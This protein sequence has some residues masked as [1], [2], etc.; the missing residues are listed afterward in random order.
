MLLSD[1]IFI[2][3]IVL[4]LGWAAIAFYARCR[5]VKFDHAINHDHVFHCVGCDYIYTDDSD[6]DRSLCP[7]C[8]KMNSSVQF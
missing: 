8:G 7:E 4:L 3:L 5:D 1:I 2:F 6:V